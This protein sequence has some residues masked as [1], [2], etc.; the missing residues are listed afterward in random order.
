MRI[1]IVSYALYPDQTSEGICAAKTARALQD[2]G[3]E[4]EIITSTTGQLESNALIET[5]LLQGI[6]VHRIN[7]KSELLPAW[8][9]PFYALDRVDRGP[10]WF[11]KQVLGRVFAI[12]YLLL[13]SSREE[14]AW[15]AAAAQ[16]IVQLC[17]DSRRR[18][19]VI[20]SRLYPASSHLAVLTALPKLPYRPHWSLYFS[21]PWPPHLYP[22]GYRSTVGPLAR[23][24]LEA[25]L[26]RLL[27]LADSLV[28]PSDRL[29]HFML[30]GSREQ[31][32][33]KACCIPHLGNSWTESP[34]YIKDNIFKIVFA[35]NLLKPRSP[36]GLFRSLN[37]LFA[38]NESMKNDLKIQ[39]VGRNNEVLR[40]DIEMHGLVDNVEIVPQLPLEETWNML[41]QADVLL[42]VEA[43][44]GEGIFM[45][46]KLSEYISAKRPILALSPPNGVVTDYLALGGGI[47]VAPDDSR[48]ITFAIAELYER[49]RNDTLSE[50][51]PPASLVESVGPSR[52]TPLYEQAFQGDNPAV[53]L[54]KT[55]SVA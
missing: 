27:K 40:G 30:S 17:K 35:G 12:P 41:C 31:F 24:R 15:V 44:M 8:T 11:K 23:R 22:T 9:A 33:R 50:L 43:H 51:A 45:P 46:S 5:P 38:D 52:I 16:T 18:F 49:W 32:R 42:I 53:A 10:A 29:M 13:G 39:L 3:H 20:H 21:D 47:R 54:H 4:V 25:Q 26:S 19:D 7:P 28:F 36:D 6:T 14:F 37:Q 34:P 48:Q 1:L 2:A 55:P